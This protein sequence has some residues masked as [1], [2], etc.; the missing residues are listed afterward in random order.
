MNKQQMLE[1]LGGF[2]GGMVQGKGTMNLSG[3]IEVTF[4]ISGDITKKT[5]QGIGLKTEEKET[6]EV[7]N[8]K[9][10]FGVKLEDLVADAEIKGGVNAEAKK[11]SEEDEKDL[12]GLEETIKK[13]LE[14]NDLK[15]IPG[16]GLKRK[17]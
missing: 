6:T 8:L 3:N 10:Q 17:K 14:N 12:D 7:I 13:F 16:L 5:K 4:N 15:I 9:G 2:I 1:T 11:N